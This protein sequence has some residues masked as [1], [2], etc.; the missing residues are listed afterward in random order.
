MVPPKSDRKWQRFLDH[1]STVEVSNLSTRMLVN[2]LKLKIAFEPTAAVKA[3]AL[4]MAHD[5]FC[6]NESAVADDIKRI[7]E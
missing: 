6:K 5:F 7:F 4:D 2:R 3:A 1:I